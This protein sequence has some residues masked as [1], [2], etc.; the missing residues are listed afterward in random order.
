MRTDGWPRLAGN[1]DDDPRFRAAARDLNQLPQ[2]LFRLVSYSD[3]PLARVAAKAGSRDY[4]VSTRPS[5]P[6]PLKEDPRASSAFPA[7]GLSDSGWTTW[8]SI[9]HRR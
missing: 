1:N 9:F 8:W 3:L 4:G 6:T 5:H 7:R 2:L